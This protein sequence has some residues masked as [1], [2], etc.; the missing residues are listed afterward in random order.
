MAE[1]LPS[2]EAPGHS[3]LRRLCILC[4]KSCGAEVARRHSDAGVDRVTLGRGY[5]RGRLLVP[6][7]GADE[8]DETAR[9]NLGDLQAFALS[10]HL[11]QHL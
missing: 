8:L 7:L 11:H 1:G 6:T 4:Q 5:G 2:A 9:T 10:S 3:R